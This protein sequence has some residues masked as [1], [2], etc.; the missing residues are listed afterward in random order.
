MNEKM[1]MMCLF[2]ISILIMNPLGINAQEIESISFEGLSDYIINTDSKEIALESVPR[3]IEDVVIEIENSNGEFSY[4]KP[5][6]GWVDGNIYEISFP[7]DFLYTQNWKVRIDVM[8]GVSFSVDDKRVVLSYGSNY[9]NPFTEIQSERPFAFINPGFTDDETTVL[10]FYASESAESI[11]SFQNDIMSLP[12]F[13]ASIVFDEAQLYQDVPANH[14]DIVIVFPLGFADQKRLYAIFN[15][16]TTH[17]EYIQD[18]TMHIISIS[19]AGDIEI[20]ETNNAEF[21]QE[22]IIADGF[23]KFQM[24]IEN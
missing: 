22:K 1:F 16:D 23:G 19:F 18:P 21:S 12:R 3:A 11:E 24:Y 20:L 14:S 5:V 17:F 7:K 9:S 13:M 6:N 2:S 15:S 4:Y 8:Y 10:S